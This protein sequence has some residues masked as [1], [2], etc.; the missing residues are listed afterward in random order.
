MVHQNYEILAKSDRVRQNYVIL[1]KSDRM[2]RYNN[3]GIIYSAQHIQL[4]H[5][6]TKLN[7]MHLEM[8]LFYN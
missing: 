2:D 3:Q 1:A 7:T 4:Y 5:A 6:M 8:V